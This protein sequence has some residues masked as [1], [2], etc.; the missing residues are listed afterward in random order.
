[1]GQ[2]LVRTIRQVRYIYELNL[3]W[4]NVV[5]KVKRNERRILF[6]TEH[7]RFLGTF[8]QMWWRG[9]QRFAYDKLLIFYVQKKGVFGS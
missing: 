7:C 3:K 2:A 9:A 5:K 8:K 1:M 4:Y 6:L